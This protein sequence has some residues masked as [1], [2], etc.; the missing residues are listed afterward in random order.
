[1]GPAGRGPEVIFE[2]DTDALVG[3]DPDFLRKYGEDVSTYYP[4]AG[5][6]LTDLANQWEAKLHKPPMAEPAWGERVIASTGSRLRR[7]WLHDM[8]NTWHYE[9]GPLGC[10]GGWLAHD[11]GCD[12]VQPPLVGVLT[13]PLI[14]VHCSGGS[15]VVAC[16]SAM[17]IAA[18]LPNR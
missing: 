18:A 2:I 4:A 16:W 14:G 6:I 9:G 11:A 12:G 7:V 1:M 8:S 10:V 13:V 17:L 5:E 15:D 3:R